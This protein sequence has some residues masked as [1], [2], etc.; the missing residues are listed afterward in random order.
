VD[1]AGAHTQM[2]GMADGSEHRFHGVY[3]EI[4]SPQRLVYTERYEMPRFGDPEWLTT[5]TFDETPAG[6]VVTHTILHRTREV[7]DGHLKAG[8]QESMIQKLMQLDGLVGGM[9]LS[10]S[11][12]I[13]L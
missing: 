6:T 7:R 3:R 12:D 5:V 9:E 11:T 8:M 1:E 2:V 4:V 13:K 10:Q